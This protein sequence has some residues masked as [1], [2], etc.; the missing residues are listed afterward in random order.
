MTREEENPSFPLFHTRA[1]RQLILLPDALPHDIA[2]GLIRKW[3]RFCIQAT[4]VA[5]ATRC[6]QFLSEDLN[7]GQDYDGITV[8]NPFRQ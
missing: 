8:T 7:H 3:L 5:K 6:R 2:T 1:T 4:T